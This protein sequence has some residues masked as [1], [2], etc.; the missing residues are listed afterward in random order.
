MRLFA[1][2]LAPYY[3]CSARTPGAVRLHNGT[4]AEHYA[5]HTMTTALVLVVKVPSSI[6]R[7]GLRGRAILEKDT[8]IQRI[9]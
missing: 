4:I 2:L 7:T 6:D 9:F 8:I 5:R 3:W 1:C